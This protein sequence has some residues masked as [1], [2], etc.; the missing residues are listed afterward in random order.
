MSSTTTT[1]TL[2]GGQLVLVTPQGVAIQ[3]GLFDDIPD[4]T[5]SFGNSQDIHSMLLDRLRALASSVSDTVDTDS[6]L[7]RKGYVKSKLNALHSGDNSF[8]SN[9]QWTG[10]NDYTG[11]VN[12][13][14]GGQLFLDDGATLTVTNCI[15]LVDGA[16][17]M[18]LGP[19]ASISD[20]ELSYLNNLTSNIQDQLAAKQNRITNFTNV[21]CNNLNASTIQ[22]PSITDNGS[23]LCSG[24]IVVSSGQVSLPSNSLTISNTSGLQSALDSKQAV[25]T[26]STD[27]NVHNISC[28]Q[29]TC[30]AAEL[31]YS[32]FSC[33][34]AATLN[35]VVVTGSI[36]LPAAS[37]AQASVTG[38][39]SALGG[40]QDTL[41]SASTITIGS[42]N[43]ISSTTLAYMDATSSVQT[44]LNSKQ[45][46]LANV[47][48]LDATSSVQTQL[49][50][51]QPALN[52]SSVVTVASLNGISSSTL[53]Y[54]DATSSVQTQLNS[55][56]ATLA[57]ASYLDATSSVQTQLN[58]KQA[59][60]ANAS[61]LDATS[62]V[63]TQLNSKQA[64]LANASYLDATSSVQT[65]LNGKQATLTTSSALSV[66]SVTVASGLT[67]SGGTITVPSASI[68][69]TALSNGPITCT[70]LTCTSEVDSGNA[71]FNSISESYIPITT[72]TNAFTLD[73]T[74]GC[75]FYLS[76]GTTL[77][78]NFS[79]SL[80]NLTTNTNR[81][82]NI[83]LIYATTGKYICN[84][85]TAYTDAGTTAISL[86]SATPL[87]V[88]GTA[89]SITTSTVMIQTFSILRLFGT[90]YCVSN[91]VGYA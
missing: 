89:P 41:T 22:G 9:S 62:S 87:W 66:A 20:V 63:Q 75:V 84:S 76:T 8:G 65:Q 24:G 4:P 45:A 35:N 21:T 12:V 37:I 38:L 33:S 78:A 86:S 68:T 30:T 60:L 88:N 79:V 11:H 49:N 72:G 51:K 27:I 16:K 64:T 31:A 42:L 82:Y 23:L 90:N 67:V 14:G 5:Y 36:T 39:V 48:Y 80:R 7:A 83:T 57:N 19:N 29:L 81:S 2:T 10:Q 15:E 32:D 74:S 50:S 40:K 43:G 69:T 25:I 46:T 91:V 52:S 56:Q 1:T 58:G 55:K 47:S 34:G 6:D 26:S 18:C 44:Q 85:V 61:Y 3:E 73:Y 13:V 28:N 53:A 70:T 77:N 59:T 54:M 71:L 17:V